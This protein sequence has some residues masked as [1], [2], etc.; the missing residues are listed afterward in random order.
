[1]R[2]VQPS[3]PRSAHDP[4]LL[5]FLTSC[6]VFGLA[7]PHQTLKGVPERGEVG[8]EGLKRPAI[9]GRVPQTCG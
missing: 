1:M 2:R 8:H 5:V 7:V 9:H 4:L 6:H 3:F